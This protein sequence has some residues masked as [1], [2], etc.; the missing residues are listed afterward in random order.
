MFAYKA[1]EERWSKNKEKTKRNAKKEISFR[2]QR[3]SVL[4]NSVHFS[5]S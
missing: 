1:C 4:V 2:I 5:I 3:V